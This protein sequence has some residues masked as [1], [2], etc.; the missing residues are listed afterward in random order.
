MTENLINTEC[1][2][3]VVIKYQLFFL[4]EKIPIL[5]SGMPVWGFL[6]S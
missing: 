1:S 2:Y 5:S 4:K 3:C 6:V